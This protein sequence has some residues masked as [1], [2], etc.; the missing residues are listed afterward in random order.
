MKTDPPPNAC[1]IS[2]KERKKERNKN[3]KSKGKGKPI[4]M[5][6]SFKIFY[7]LVLDL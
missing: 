7:N 5:G 6:L 4:C 1:N 2:D 3:S